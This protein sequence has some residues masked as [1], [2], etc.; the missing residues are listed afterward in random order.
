MPIEIICSHN[1]YLSCQEWDPGMMVQISTVSPLF[2]WGVFFTYANYMY[3]EGYMNSR[4]CM[5]VWLSSK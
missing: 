3:G 2:S 1:L 4:F 5:F